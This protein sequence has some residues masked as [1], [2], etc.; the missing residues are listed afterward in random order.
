M[1]VCYMWRRPGMEAKGIGLS[2]PTVAKV[3]TNIIDFRLLYMVSL[4]DNIKY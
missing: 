3:C 2:C 4:Y 1:H